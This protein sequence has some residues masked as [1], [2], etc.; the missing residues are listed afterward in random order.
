MSVGQIRHVRF[1]VVTRLL[2]S[3]LEGWGLR[4]GSANSC[5]VPHRGRYMICGLKSKHDFGKVV[6]QELIRL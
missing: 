6:W 4:L 2:A 3:W 5:K 1:A